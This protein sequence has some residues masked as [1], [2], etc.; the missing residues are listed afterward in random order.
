MAKRGA[1]SG[2]YAV[3]SAYYDHVPVMD[4]DSDET[5]GI[6][7]FLRDEIFAPSKRRGNLETAMSI[8]VFAGAVA[9][10][11]NYGELLAV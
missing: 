8:I 10:L 3:P 4:S 11:R 9:L 2:D 1:L 6:V 7:R 5:N